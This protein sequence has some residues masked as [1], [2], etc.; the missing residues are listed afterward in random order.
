[1]DRELDRGWGLGPDDHQ[2]LERWRR[3]WI[4]AI[5]ASLVADVMRPRIASR[6]IW[7]TWSGKRTPLIGTKAPSPRATAK[8]ERLLDGGVQIDAD[9]IAPLDPAR[10]RPWARFETRLQTSP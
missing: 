5:A 2:E 3:F 4:N 9:P 7:D 6:A 1:V 8:I 10:R